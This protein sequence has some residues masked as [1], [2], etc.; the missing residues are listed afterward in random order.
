MKHVRIASP[1]AAT[2][3][4]S[5]TAT[6]CTRCR[7]STIPFR[8]ASTTMT[9]TAEPTSRQNPG[10]GPG[11]RALPSAAAVSA[12]LRTARKTVHSG[13]V[14]RSR[15]PPKT[16]R[17]PSPLRSRLRGRGRARRAGA[18]AASRARRRSPLEDRP[19][20]SRPR[21]STTE[22]AEKL[23]LPKGTV[24]HHLKVL[25]KAGLVHVVRTRQVRAVTEK[26]Y[27]RVAR[28][29]LFESTDADAR[30][31]P[32]P[33]RSRPPPRRRGDPSRRRRRPDDLRRRA[34][35]AHRRRRQASQPP[36]EEADRRL[37]RRRVRGRRGVRP[38]CRPVRTSRRCVGL[39]ATS[40]ITPT[41]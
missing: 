4:P 28:L 14:A 17:T 35:T 3:V 34:G 25:E 15:L 7:A 1:A 5:R 20:P 41:S 32:E 2:I 23:G 26:F 6:A 29:F 33:R 18:R 30:G 38:R 24:G 36:P 19:A 10:S 13:I 9:S 21:L 37:P 31:R 16:T 11:V 8:R 40:G 12:L 27:G 39:P 22:L